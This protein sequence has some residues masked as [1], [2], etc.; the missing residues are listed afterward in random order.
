MI[1]KLSKNFPDQTIILRPHPVEKLETY[2]NYLSNLYNVHIIREGSAKEWIL[3]ASMVIH[4]AC[5]T[6]IESF[7]AEKPVISFYPH[8]EEAVEFLIA[9]GSIVGMLGLIVGIL[10]WFGLGQFQRHKMLGVIVV[11]V[12][13][14]AVCG[15]HTGIKYFGIRL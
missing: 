12:I 1:K 14:L 9:L 8:F 13:L 10:G 2:T 11:S 15:I 4:S 6:G 5:T 3:N 7:L